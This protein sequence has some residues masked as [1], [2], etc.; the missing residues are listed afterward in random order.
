V[1]H[2]RTIAVIGLGYV[3]LP[4]ALAFARSGAAVIGYDADSARIAELMAGR[5][6]TRQ[7]DAMR[8]A[9]SGLALTSNAAELAAADFYIITVPASCDADHRPDL[10]LLLRASEQVGQALRRGG[11]V[12]YESTLYPGATEGEC[13]PVLERASG[14]LSGVDFA[15]GYS[16][17]RINPGDPDHR[18]A[19]VQKVIASQDARTLDMMAQVY[20]SVVTAGL[21][22]A[23]SI[24]A[25]ELAKAFENTQRDVNIALMNEFSEICRALELDTADVLATAASKWNFLPFTP[26]LVGGPCITTVPH[27]LMDAARRANVHPDLMSKARGINEGVSARVVRETLKLLPQGA[28]RVTVLGLTFKENVPD[29]RNSEV[30]TMVRALQSAGVAAQVN[31]PVANPEEANQCGIKLVDVSALLPADAVI[32]AVPHDCY[33]AQGWSLIQP[34]LKD[35]GGVVVDIKARLDR[36][37]KPGNVVLWRL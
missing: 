23:P 33:L 16:P 26:G 22:R 7:V 8:P 21:Y 30:V 11:I 35:T 34:L 20:G 4:L 6:R 2:G 32:L 31:D 19:T 27:L 25:A 14:L 5:D 10:S 37:S 36:A 28:E 12:V 3:G 1:P 15:V 24:R 17:E 18:L 13:I 29:V 9:E